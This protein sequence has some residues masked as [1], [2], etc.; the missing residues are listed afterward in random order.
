VRRE[1][2]P[3]LAVATTDQTGQRDPLRS[4]WS[5]PRRTGSLHGALTDTQF[6]WNEVNWD[7]VRWDEWYMNAP[8][9][10]H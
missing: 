6:G 3:G 9:L 7:E 1:A 8:M 5:Q 10:V 2:T 4:D